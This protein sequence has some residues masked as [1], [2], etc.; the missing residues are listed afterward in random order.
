M[1]RDVHLPGRIAA[2]ACIAIPK[3]VAGGCLIWSII[4]REVYNASEVLCATQNQ[5]SVKFALLGTTPVQIR[6]A[7]KVSCVPPAARVIPVRQYTIP[8]LMMM[9][10]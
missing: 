1:E 3:D 9:Q 5:V 8:A 10:H 7:A 2:K 6:L 4:V